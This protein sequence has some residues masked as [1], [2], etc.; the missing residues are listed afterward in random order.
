M[1]KFTTRVLSIAMLLG[2]TAVAA[3]AAQWPNATYPDTLNVYKVQF[4]MANPGPGFPAL[5]D[6]V[7]GVGGI[8]TGFDAKP[9]G[10]AFYIQNNGNPWTGIDV[11]TGSFNY[12]SSPFNVQVG[13]SVVVYGK[14]QEFGGG[15][16]IEGLD[17]TQGTND[18]IVRIVSSGNPLPPF[19]GGTTTGLKEV[20]KGTLPM[21]QWEGMLV[22]INGPLTVA[23]NTGVGTNSFLVVSAA[24]P[25]D[26]VNIDGNTL[27]TYA[28]PAVGTTVDMV[29][30]IYEERNRGYRI[31][32][33]NGDDIVLATP[34]NAID[35]YPLTDTQIRVVFDRSVTAATATNV[36]NYSL[37]S[38]GSVDAATMDGTTAVLLD[39]TNGLPHGVSETVTVSGVAGLANGLVMTAPQSRTFIN[40]LLS[41]AE[42]QAPN[43]DSLAGIPCLDRSRFAGGGGQTSQGNLGPRLSMSAV[44]TG[45]F[46]PLHYVADAAGG[47]RSGVSVFAPPSLPV[48]GRLFFF[49]GQVQEFFGE[50]EVVAIT[51]MRD[52]GAVGALAPAMP[53]LSAIDEDGCDP[54]E[55]LDDSE[56]YE[57]MI[58]RVPYAKVILAE[59]LVTPPANGFHISNQAGTDSIFVS[60]LNGVLNPYTSKPLGMTT[61]VT[62]ALH[63]SNN[64]FRI[65]PRDYNDIVDHGMNVG[66]T[67]NVPAQ[68]RFAAFPN[69]GVSSRIEFSL[70]VESDVQ[71]GVYDVLGRQVTQ[72]AKGRMPA[73]EYTRLWDGRTAGGK[74]GPGVYF[75]RLTVGEKSYTVRTVRVAE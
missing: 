39:I 62:G 68:V 57:G 14:I 33:R 74:A 35:A 64:S 8:V 3:Q 41:C 23:R 61:T 29:R 58:V 65:C 10:F 18:V 12:N 60:N 40:G 26:S 9:S 51:D 63:Y 5:L 34:P 53:D 70:P 31:Q 21:E 56:D 52:M 28:P 67:P 48:R 15:T 1:T 13:D 19:Y 45:N 47:P 55:T 30:G 72:L 42:I 66:V 36:N 24:A 54:T 69:P 59:G 16:E 37:A 22:Q 38:F 6:T 50:T 44:V 25:S 17:A 75:Y 73:G 46:T 43:P 49:S 11:F 7:S 2:I 20:P 71:L 27:T 32:L 4:G